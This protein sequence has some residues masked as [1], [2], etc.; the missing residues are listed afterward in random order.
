MDREFQMFYR[1][2]E[3]RHARLGANRRDQRFYG[4]GRGRGRRANAVSV[5]AIIQDLMENPEHL[6]RKNEV[7]AKLHVDG[8]NIRYVKLLIN[9]L[10]K[11]CPSNEITCALSVMLW[12]FSP[13]F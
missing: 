4:G 11:I 3:L 7:S 9:F 6:K 10:S 8:E 13:L 12:I 1:V 5:Q 2:R